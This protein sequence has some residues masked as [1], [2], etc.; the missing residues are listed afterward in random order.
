MKRQRGRNRKNYNNLNRQMES[1]GPDVKVRGSATQIYDK[2]IASARDATVNGNR[3]KAENF[4]QHA[5]HYLRLINHQESL[6]QVERN[7]DSQTE[8]AESQIQNREQG[9]TSG[10]AVDNVAPVDSVASVATTNGSDVQGSANEPDKATE[11]DS[12]RRRPAPVRACSSE[13]ASEM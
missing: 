1:N 7:E 6:R 10:E 3:I 2:Y 13:P 11:N 5:E 9:V 4:R 8:S 12:H